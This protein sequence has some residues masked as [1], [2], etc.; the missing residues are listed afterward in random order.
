MKRK[1]QQ[2]LSLFEAPLG[3][4]SQ[5]LTE[6]T[7]RLPEAAKIDFPCPKCGGRSAKSVRPRENGGSRYCVG[8][9]LSEDKTD[10]FYFSPEGECPF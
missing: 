6:T 7:S 10:M 5:L 2:N 8:G 4:P 3:A 1:P 9:C